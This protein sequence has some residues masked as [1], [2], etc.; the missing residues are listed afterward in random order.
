MTLAW[1]GVTIA[2]GLLVGGLVAAHYSRE[3]GL[4]LDP[5]WNIGL[6]AGLGGIVGSRLLFLLEQGGPVLG[7]HGFSLAGG[8][9][10]AGLLIAFYIGR[11]R[12]SLR[13]LDAVGLALPLG[14]AV[15][16][17]GDVINGEHYGD[18]S[19][20]FL[21]VRNSHPDAL[22]PNP[23]LAYHSGGMYEVMLGLLIFAVVWPL[24]HRFPVAG[25]IAALVLGLVA[26]G[27]FAEFFFRSD[28]PD[29]AI[30]L[31]NTQWI[32]LSMLAFAVAGWYMAGRREP[33]GVHR[34]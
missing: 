33:S 19:E 26:T 16:R 4:E 14:L 32:S 18:Q 9:I 21:A 23:E 12:L 1:H 28:S 5:L 29:L 27:R 30:G 15:G 11:G 6:L 13:Y 17:L 3:E 24:R 2:L 25:R 22:T 31:S 8:V 10:L 20:F 7:T 34:T